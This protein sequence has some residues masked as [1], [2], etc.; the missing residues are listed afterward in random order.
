M[1]RIGLAIGL[2]G[3]AVALPLIGGASGWHWY[4][5]GLM[6]LHALV[7]GLAAGLWLTRPLA[8]VGLGTAAAAMVT[9]NQLLGADF[10]W[11][12]DTVFFAVVLGGPA[13]IGALF[14]ERAGEVRRLEALQA[15][16]DE[17]QRVDVAAAR[18]DEQ[19]RVQQLVH[20]RLA[21]N[22]AGIV[23]RA[24]GARRAHDAGALP[25]L[26][27]E[28]RGVLDRLRES[29]GSLHEP[30][31]RPVSVDLASSPG[32]RPS[33]VDVVLAVGVG[34]GIAVESV[35]VAAT[36]GPGWANVLAGLAVATPLVW[37]RGHPIA[38]VAASLGIATLMS[39]WLTPL[40]VMVTPVALLVVTFYSIGAWC[41]GRS[42]L[43]GWALAATGNVAIYLVS[44]SGEGLDSG[45]LAIPI[46]MLGAVALGRISAARHSRVLRAESVVRQLQQGRGAAVRLAMA[47]ERQ[48]LAGELHD[49]VAHAMTVVCL[50]AGAQGRGGGDVDGALRTIAATSEQCLAELREGLDAIEGSALPLDRHRIGDMGRRMGVDLEVAVPRPLGGP[51]GGVA[52]RVVRES[53]VNVARH[54]HGAS[55][56]VSAVHEGAALR[57]DVVNGPGSE[58]RPTTGSGTG[59]A[60]LADT[61]EAAGGQLKWGPLDDGGFQVSA[62]IPQEV[63]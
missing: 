15:E 32:P 35:V 58:S 18:L 43:L 19:G 29:L 10:H 54:A 33:A 11:L 40:A 24:E 21:E 37:R 61:V 13:L 38:A 62:V 22:I 53:L 16:L 48:S 8:A 1:P 59:L 34:V 17:Q 41:R 27:Q 55:T 30:A 26:E 47:Q 2:I 56:S 9:A 6:V 36:R 28:A 23:L 49:S 57:V 51:A 60:G 4:V 7:A 12:D 52:F 46:E 50:H 31:P 44:R 14:A 20:S 25:V 42:W 63:P 3:S 39:A 5:D 45:A